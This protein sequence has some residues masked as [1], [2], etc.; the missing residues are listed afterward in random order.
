MMSAATVVARTQPRMPLTA[1]AC[2]NRCSVAP[3]RR[4]LSATP[5]SPTT[6]PSGARRRKM[7]GQMTR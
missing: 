7:C 2:R 6:W 3:A 4:G 5:W 1:G